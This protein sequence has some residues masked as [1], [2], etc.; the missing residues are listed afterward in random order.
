MTHL[1]CQPVIA[2]DVRRGAEDRGDQSY[3]SYATAFG[4]E[5]IE[6]TNP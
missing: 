6:R 1:R 4:G 3:Q 5:V 2:R